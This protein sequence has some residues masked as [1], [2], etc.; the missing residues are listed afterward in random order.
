MIE[1]RGNQA[2]QSGQKWITLSNDRPLDQLGQHSRWRVGLGNPAWQHGI[3]AAGKSRFRVAA[4]PEGTREFHRH[5]A[6]Q[7]CRDHARGR[8]HV[9]FGEHPTQLGQ[10]RLGG[11]GRA[12]SASWPRGATGAKRRA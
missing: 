5:E 2:H 9:G 4:K 1:Y 6:V 11:L 3:E 10:E 7:E 12:A 8:Q